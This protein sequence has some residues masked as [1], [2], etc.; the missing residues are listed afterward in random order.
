M[1]FIYT[2]I[3]F[4]FIYLYYI[5]AIYFERSR[6]NIL[7]LQQNHK[8]QVR[9]GKKEHTHERDWMHSKRNQHTGTYIFLKEMKKKKN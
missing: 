2:E 6:L 1:L 9:R 3:F 7:K 8:L 4:F 5:N